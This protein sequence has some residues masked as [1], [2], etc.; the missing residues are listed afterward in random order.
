MHGI[1]FIRIFMLSVAVSLTKLRHLEDSLDDWLD[2]QLEN[3]LDDDYLV[4]DCPGIF[5]QSLYAPFIST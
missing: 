4:F 5:F 3:Y 2:E 1:C